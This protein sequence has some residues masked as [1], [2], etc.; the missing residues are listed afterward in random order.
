MTVLRVNLRL[1]LISIKQ[2]GSIVFLDFSN[3]C[4]NFEVERY[5]RLEA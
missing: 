1:K 3:V 2:R 5:V 4:F